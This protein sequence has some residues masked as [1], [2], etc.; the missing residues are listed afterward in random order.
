M[1]KVTPRMMAIMNMVERGSKLADIGT[2]HGIMPVVLVL[3]KKV[4]SVIA[5]DISY[6]SLEKAIKLIKKYGLGKYI[7][8]RVGYGLEVLAPYEVDTVI[9]AGLSGKQITEIIGT[10][11]HIVEGIKRFIL[12][13][14]QHSDYLRKWLISNLYE[15]VDEDLVFENKKFYQIIVAKRGEQVINDEIFYE[16]GPKLFEK[17]HPLLKKFIEGK[18]TKT[19][20]IIENLKNS[21]LPGNI[22]KI[23]LLTEK[24]R[25]YEVIYDAL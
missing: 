16:I 22:K 25:K 4:K 14:V 18:I 6:K 24:L 7:D 8:T 2:D 5:S 13:P 15:I 9:I 20:R 19:K 1:L 17:R 12:Q 3:D 11:P 10:S 21:K 23:N